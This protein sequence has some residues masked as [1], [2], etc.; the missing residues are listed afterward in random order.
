M[1]NH[2]RPDRHIQRDFFIADILDAAPK[3]DMASMEHPIFAL[4]AGDKRIRY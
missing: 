3:D 4:R 2:L 1:T